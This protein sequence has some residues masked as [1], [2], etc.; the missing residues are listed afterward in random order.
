MVW[1]ARHISVGGCH[2]RRCSGVGKL[3]EGDVA[4]D[5]VGREGE[6][7]VN[8]RLWARLRWNFAMASKMVRAPAVEAA[9]RFAAVGYLVVLCETPKTLA[10]EDFLIARRKG[11][12]RS[13]GRPA[14]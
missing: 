4:V 3:R 10:P 1:E 2:G 5:G 14:H 13:L 7:G 6:T 8:A 11:G 12:A 9:A